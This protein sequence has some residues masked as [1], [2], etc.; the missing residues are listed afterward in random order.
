MHLGQG[1][2]SRRPNAS[3]GGP[4]CSGHPAPGL[5]LTGIAIV[6]FFL[7]VALIGPFFAPH[8]ATEQFR[9]QAA[10]AA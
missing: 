9:R 8:G 3:P 1:A 2:A 5:A 10:A 4:G 7:I 6:G